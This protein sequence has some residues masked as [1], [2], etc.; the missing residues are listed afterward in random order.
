MDPAANYAAEGRLGGPA[1]FLT[2]G[3]AGRKPTG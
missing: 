3:A 2:E 1:L